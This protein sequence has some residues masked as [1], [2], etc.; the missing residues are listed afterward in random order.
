VKY[1]LIEHFPQRGF[2]QCRKSSLHFFFFSFHFL[3]ANFFL[4]GKTERSTPP[5]TPASERTPSSKKLQFLFKS[6]DEQLCPDDTIPVLV[7]IPD[8]VESMDRNYKHA[9]AYIHKKETHIALRRLCPSLPSEQRIAKVS[10]LSVLV[11]LSPLFL[12]FAATL[13]TLVTYLVT[14]VTETRP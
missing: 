7:H 6:A 13:S 14:L 5:F 4:L 1:F 2:I 3:F 9:K 12:A 8:C 10:K 11:I